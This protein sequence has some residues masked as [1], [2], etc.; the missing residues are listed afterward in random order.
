MP[1]PF[2]SLPATYVHDGTMFQTETND[3]LAPYLAAPPDIVHITSANAPMPN[4]SGPAFP[5]EGQP[6]Y[7]EPP[8]LVQ[9]RFDRARV[10]AEKLHGAGVKWVLPYICNQSLAGNP[11]TRTGIWMFWDHWDDYARFDIGP[12]PEADP[13]DWMAREPDGELHFN[14]EM[15]HTAFTGYDQ[16]RYAPCVNN[17]YY[18]QY[19]RVIVGLIGRAG[20]DGVFVDNNNL[21]C[22]CEWCQEAFRRRMMVEYTAEQRRELFGW[23]SDDDVAMGICGNRFQWLK[24]DP[25]FHEFLAETL[26]PEEMIRWFGTDDLARAKLADAGNGWLWGRANEYRSWVAARYSPEQRLARWGVPSLEGWGI[27]TAGDRL[28]WAETKRFWAESIS[29]NHKLIKECGAEALGREFRVVPNWGNMQQYEDVAFRAEIGHDV[30]RWTPYMDMNFWEDDGDPGRVAPGVYL[31]FALQ[32]RSAFANGA[33]SATMAALPQD[34]PT[35][36]LAHAEAAATG[37]SAFIQRMPEF[38]DLRARYAKLYSE[39]SEWFEGHESAAEVALFF[40][41]ENLHLGNEAHVHEVYRWNHY[42]GDQQVPLDFVTEA[43]VR[44]LS[45]L[46][47]YSVVIAPRV[48]HLADEHCH[49]L[50]EFVPPRRDA[51]ARRRDRHPRHAGARAEGRRHRGDAPPGDRGRPRARA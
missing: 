20:F 22:Y 25:L 32:Y 43:Q 34:E 29:E 7:I 3:W 39:H 51:G 5:I 8:E 37:G 44:D 6:D 28:L 47:R 27:R 9:K 38:P 17:P 26:S 41:M 40:S 33:R 16:F 11:E 42:L 24:G 13:I 14:Y 12:R 50:A 19:Q 4:T 31:D 2:T 48:Q 49:S 23:E 30:E 15:R 45:F 10:I 18:Q 21:N 35:C 46:P 36:E 1:R